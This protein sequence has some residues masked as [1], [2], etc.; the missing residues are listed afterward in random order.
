MDT[1]DNKLRQLLFFHSSFQVL[2]KKEGIIKYNRKQKQLVSHELCYRIGLRV[3][4]V[5]Y[6]DQCTSDPG[7]FLFEGA[8][9][10]H[11]VTFLFCCLRG[12]DVLFSDEAWAV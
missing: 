3:D 9:D 11:N 7:G 4:E 8:D 1:M 2:I 6:Y 12:R 10:R 5:P